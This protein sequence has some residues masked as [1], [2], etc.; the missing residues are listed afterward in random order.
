MITLTQMKQTM[1]AMRPI[2]IAGKTPTKP[3]AAV[4]VARPA[5]EPVIVPNMVGLPVKS[6]SRTAHVRPAVAAA[7]CVTTRAWTAR[8]F[9]ASALP[10]L[11]P[12]QP[13]QSR[14]APST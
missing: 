1:L 2:A 3:E 5:I 11:K 8:P 4:I 14:A 10:A 12:N 9:A 13:N 7:R 6:H